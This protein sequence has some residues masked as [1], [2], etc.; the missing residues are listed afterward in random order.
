[1]WGRVQLDV[2]RGELNQAEAYLLGETKDKPL[3]EVHKK[4]KPPTMLEIKLMAMTYARQLYTE[5][6]YEKFVEN[7]DM[8]ED[9]FWLNILEDRVLQ[10]VH[11]SILKFVYAALPY[12]IRVSS[13]SDLG[14]CFKSRCAPIGSEWGERGVT[15]QF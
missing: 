4:K 13:E 11:V 2:M 1:M 15:G 7:R 6:N 3:G 14:L 8:W 5:G 9:Q 10:Y 12:Q